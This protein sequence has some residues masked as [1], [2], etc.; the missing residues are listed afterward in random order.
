MDMPD[1]RTLERNG[2][3][4]GVTQDSVTQDSATQDSATQ[5][6]AIEFFPNATTVRA[7]LESA[8]I[9]VWSWDADANTLT[10]S[11]NLESLHGLPPKSFDG[12]LAGFLD[13]IHSEDRANVEA[14]LKEAMHA[15]SPFRAR[16][17]TPQ[18]KGHDECWLEATGT[19]IAEGGK[20]KGMSGLCYDVTGRV[21]LE[22]E[23]RNRA[24]QQEALAQLGERALAEPDLE[25]LLNDA[26]STVALTL[27]VD[28]VNILELLPGDRELLLRAGFGWKGDFVG[29]VVTAAEPGSFARFTLDSSVPVVIEDFA[30]ETRFEVAS[31]LKEHNCV[32]GMNVTIAGRGGRAYGILGVCSNQKRRFSAQDTVFFA[33]VANL[34]T[35]AIQRRQ[36]EQRHELMIRDM[37]HRTGNL[38]SQLLALF[39]QTARTSK[40]IPDLTAKYQARVLAMANAHRLITE[41]GWQSIPIME[42]L[43][44][45]LGPYLDR[46]SLSGPNVDL[47]PDPVFNLSAALH[48]LAANAI[49]H[50]SLS[51]SKGQLDL[52][53]SV[54][55]TARGLT[56]MLDWVEKNG[57]PAR[58]PRKTGFGT[59][60]IDLVIG[61]Q[62]NGEV[63]RTYSSTG[64]NVKMMVPL[65]HERWPVTTPVAGDG[66]GSAHADL[67]TDAPRDALPPG[68]QAP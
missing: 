19:V 57:P 26:V 12:T 30:G 68:A 61:R 63:I 65:T 10:W 27:S 38:F 11:I 9:G 24:K 43:H 17:R 23:L 39:S 3:V 59:R 5:D 67:P 58:R 44:V 29:T 33:A 16:Y 40:S 32:C 60:L 22:N 21:S 25:R 46:A 28:F 48:E 2:P 41:G 13:S 4:R 35:G 53:W 62:L 55:R 56:L 51:R 6:F 47:E 50:G 7:G 18:L 34:L 52:S 54:E 8:R 42:L 66:P 36:L 37:R 20:A 64:L 31:Y 49:K 14:L 1:K 15:Q 45:V